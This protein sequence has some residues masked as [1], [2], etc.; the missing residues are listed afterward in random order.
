MTNDETQ[1]KEKTDALAKT[2][3]K[4]EVIKI[5][6][7]EVAIARQ[8]GRF[9]NVTTTA[10][11]ELAKVIRNTTHTKQENGK[12]AFEEIV[13]NN[14]AVA[15]GNTE[16]KALGA[17]SQWTETL[18]LLGGTKDAR[19]NL[20]APEQQNQS[21]TVINIDG[22]MV[23]VFHRT[24]EELCSR[25]AKYEAVPDSLRITNLDVVKPTTLKPSF[26][27]APYIDAEL[28]QQNAP[29]PAQPSFAKPKHERRVDVVPRKYCAQWGKRK[30]DQT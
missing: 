18:D 5:R 10:A 7:R 3:A 13:L 20:Q 11:Q 17:V 21:L 8:K 23:S 9:A 4:L 2:E 24:I 27:E 26:A 22:A 16:P 29:A 30:D 12:T 14:N 6:G 28:V 15:I 1:P 25:L 19:K